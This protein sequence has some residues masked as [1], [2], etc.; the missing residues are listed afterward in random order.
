MYTV[1]FNA[2]YN[3]VDFRVV[4]T[5][6]DAAGDPVDINTANFYMDVVPKIGTPTPILELETGGEISLFS[7]GSDGKLVIH[8]DHLVMEP[9]V[10]GSYKYDLVMDRSGTSEIVMRGNFKIK[11][12]VTDI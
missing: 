12:G 1:N 9:L 6:N 10:P 2:V 4:V 7:D 5:L 8:V 11:A 3:N